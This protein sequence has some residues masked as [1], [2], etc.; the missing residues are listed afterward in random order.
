MRRRGRPS[1]AA[2][3]N[4]LGP[5]PRACSGK[6]RVLGDSSMCLRRW[7][8]IV[9][10]VVHAVLAGDREDQCAVREAGRFVRRLRRATVKAAD[11][12]FT[13][14]GTVLITGGSGRSG[15]TSRDGSPSAGHLISCWPRGA[16]RR[17]GCGRSGPRARSHGSAGHLRGAGS[18]SK[19]RSR[20]WRRNSRARSTRYAR[21]STRRA[22][23]R[24]ARAQPRCRVRGP[25]H[26]AEAHHGA[27]S[28]GRILE[29]RPLCVRTVFL[30]G[31]PPRQCGTGRLRRGQRR[32]GCPR[33]AFRAQ[34]LPAIPWP[35]ARGLETE[36]RRVM[37]ANGSTSWA[38]HRR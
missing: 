15:R 24:P 25:R 32:S 1:A 31:G 21:C 30:R 27:A 37:P 14:K 29:A 10:Q 26:R 3:G 23:C 13:P 5:L 36:C 17:P 38:C 4:G 9:P 11:Q 33:G 22:S 8:A 2:P 28:G 12:A 16:A 35:G 20:L 7:T 34:G 6:R 18:R 19:A